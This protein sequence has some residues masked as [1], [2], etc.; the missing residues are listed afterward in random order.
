MSW[1]LATQRRGRDE[2]SALLTLLLKL[3]ETSSK[4]KEIYFKSD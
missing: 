1:Y 4:K 2:H 3:D